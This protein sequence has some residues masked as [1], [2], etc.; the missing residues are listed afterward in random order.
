VTEPRHRLIGL[1]DDDMLGMYRQMVLARKVSERWSGLAVQG[2]AAIA[3]PCDGHEAAQ[4]GTAWALR[5]TDIVFPYYRS[6]A[7]A[8]AR[9]MTP[10]ELFLDIFARKDSP[11]SGGRQMPGH[12]TSPRLGMPTTGSSVATQIPHAV[13]AALASKLRQEDAVTVV[14]FGDG[15]SS[16]GDFHEGLNFAGI[17]HLPVIFVCEN[18]RYAISVPFELQSAV[19][20][21]AGRGASYNIPGLPIDG[22]DILTVY[23]TMKEAVDRARGHRGPTLIEC[24]VYRF[25]FHTSHVGREDF[26]TKEEI[27]AARARDPLPRCKTYLESVGLWDDRHEQTLLA[28]VKTEIDAAVDAAEAA[29]AP[30]AETALDHVIGS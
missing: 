11:S 22:M 5:P 14:Y 15:A 28:E 4:V 7:A 26:R 3:I 18:N 30:P 17:H 13:G 10:T 25:G 23:E 2:K 21:V 29:P 16:K 1:T 9:G 24:R 6:T 20:S 8:L 27:Q 12:W 19:P